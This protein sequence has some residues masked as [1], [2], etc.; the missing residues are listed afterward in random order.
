MRLSINSFFPTSIRFLLFLHLCLALCAVSTAHFCA[1]EPSPTSDKKIAEELLVTASP[2]SSS[3]LAF[4]GSSS[5]VSSNRYSGDGSAHFQDIIGQIPNLNWSSGSN[6]PRYFQIRGV[7]DYEQYEGAP[8]H[9]VGF[10]IDDFDFSGIGGPSSLFD[11]YQSELVRGPQGLMYGTNA[12]AGVIQLR[13]EDPS[14]QTSARGE[15]SL[16]SDD[17]SQGGLAVGG[18]LP[19]TNEKLQLRISANHYQSDGFRTNDFLHRTD[20]NA[21]DEFT[22]RIKLRAIL[23]EKTNLDLSLISLDF[24]NGYDAFAIDNS[25]HTQSDRPGEDSQEAKGLSAKLSTRFLDDLLFTSTSTILDSS[26]DYSYDGDWGNNSFWE[27]FSPYDYFSKTARDRRNLSQEFRIRSDKENFKVGQDFGYLLG[28][29]LGQISEESKIRNDQDGVTYDTLHSDFQTDNFAGFGQIETPI[30]PDTS[31]TTGLRAEHRSLD[32]SDSRGTDATPSESL[33]AGNVSLNHKATEETLLYGLVSRGYRGGGFNSGASIPKERTRFDPEYLWNFETGLKNYYSPLKLK[34]NL[35]LFV[36]KRQDQQI[37][38][39]VQNDPNDPL[40]FTYLTD[41]AASGRNLGLEYEGDIQ[42]T[43]RLKVSGSLGILKTKFTDFEALDTSVI[44]REAAHAPT[45]QYAVAPRYQITE[46][47]FLKVEVRGMDAF[48]FA[49]NHNA[50]STP[51]HVVNSAIGYETGSWSW[52]IWAKNLLDER[53]ATRG[54][55]FGNE[56]PDFTNKEYIQ[57]GDPLQIGT[58]LSFYF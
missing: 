45:W 21:R 24:N 31:I 17:L 29:Y 44:G 35:S 47:V 40:S 34:S 54:F 53:Y 16:G 36:A 8:N 57:R 41:N 58:T 19:G 51:Y 32:Y 12:L 48:Y 26:Q 37:G 52:T 15:V 5:V 4:S 25:L 1:A 6:R 43:D 23:S 2:L 55:F 30:L 14:P 33:V 7:G 50:R 20:T 56:P 42:A 3:D 46:N 39:S 13:T 22:G 38:I 10:Y 9:A 27:P 18:A 28:M 11:T 49:D